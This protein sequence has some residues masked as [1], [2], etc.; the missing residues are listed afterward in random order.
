MAATARHRGD[1][2]GA[3][4]LPDVVVEARA[5]VAYT[6]FLDLDM[7]WRFRLEGAPSSCR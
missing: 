6:Y 1:L 5:P 4:A 3:L 2:Q 7:E